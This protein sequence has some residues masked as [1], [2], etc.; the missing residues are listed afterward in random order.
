MRS[1][2]ASGVSFVAY[3]PER[4]RVERAVAAAPRGFDDLVLVERFD[5]VDLEVVLLKD[6]SNPQSAPQLG[7]AASGWRWSAGFTSYGT[8]E[9]VLDGREHVSL[10]FLV[11]EANGRFLVG[12][13]LPA[14]TPMRV[15]T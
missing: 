10:I 1:G 3:G 6:R 15:G 9:V 7:L 2:D 14:D 5:V 12:D 4:R 8:N 13:R 11:T